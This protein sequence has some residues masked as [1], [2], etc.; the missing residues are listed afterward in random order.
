[1]S[2]DFYCRVETLLLYSGVKL[3]VCRRIVAYDSVDDR[4]SHNMFVQSLMIPGALV[5]AYKRL[6]AMDEAKTY[7]TPD[8]EKFVI[9]GREPL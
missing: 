8:T 3:A 4:A 5:E 2:V 7:C 1:M 6:L 9:M